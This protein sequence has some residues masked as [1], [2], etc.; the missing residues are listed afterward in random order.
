M[1]AASQDTQIESMSVLRYH[2]K[3]EWEVEFYGEFE[4]EFDALADSAQDSI[5]A[6]AKLLAMAGP[7]LG[8]PYA[9]TL[10]GSRYA[11]MKELRC[12]ADHGVWRVAFAFDPE[13]RA[14]LLAAGDK[15]GTKERLFYKRLI[16]K[17]DDRFSRHLATRKRRK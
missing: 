8:R 9:D 3:M 16:A 6:A 2:R 15:A 7:R 10:K 1:R 13:R 14:V 5:L 17:A 11:N 4:E 12:V